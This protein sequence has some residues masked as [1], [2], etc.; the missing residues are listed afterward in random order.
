M[1][2]HQPDIHGFIPWR[3]PPGCVQSASG[4]TCPSQWDG[5]Q[6]APVAWRCRRGN[7]LGEILHQLEMKESRYNTPSFTARVVRVVTN[8]ILGVIEAPMAQKWKQIGCTFACF[9]QKN[10]SI[11]G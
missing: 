6:R 7:T 9:N 2:N 5:G 8:N 10:P 3:A 11:L 4:P 1:E